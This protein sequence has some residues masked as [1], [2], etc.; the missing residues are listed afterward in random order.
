MAGR[1]SSGAARRTSP[2]HHSE[3]MFSTVTPQPSI[4]FKP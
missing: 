3:G 2:S 4:A 1:S